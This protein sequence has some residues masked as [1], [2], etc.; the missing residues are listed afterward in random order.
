MRHIDQSMF[1][2]TVKTDKGIRF[3]ECYSVGE[4]YN[5]AIQ[6]DIRILEILSVDTQSDDIDNFLVYGVKK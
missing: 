4:V 2:Y 3:Y 1:Y 5:M 6:D